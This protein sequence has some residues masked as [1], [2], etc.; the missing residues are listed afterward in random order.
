MTKMAKMIDER[1]QELTHQ[2]HRVM[3]VNSMNTVKELLPILISGNHALLH[4]EPLYCV[5][6]CLCPFL[7]YSIFHT[8]TFWAA[9][10]WCLLWVLFHLSG[11]K[12]FVTTKTSGSHGVEEALKNRNFTFEKMSAEINEII[13]VLQLTS[14]DEDAW[15][16]KVRAINY[17]CRNH[18]HFCMNILEQ[19]ETALLLECLCFLLWITAGSSVCT[20]IDWILSRLTV[21]AHSQNAFGKRP[22]T[23]DFIQR[24]YS[25]L[26]Y[27]FLT[28]HALCLI[29]MTLSQMRSK[30]AFAISP[31]YKQCLKNECFNFLCLHVAG[32]IFRLL[33]RNFSSAL[34]VLLL[35]CP[36][37]ISCATSFSFGDT[38]F[39]D[40]FFPVGMSSST[41]VF[42]SFFLSFCRFFPPSPPVEGKPSPLSPLGCAAACLTD[43]CAVCFVVP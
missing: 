40:T 7:H 29:R 17:K 12:I 8:I 37:T 13:R 28:R 9:I 1:Q 30:N 39:G 42:M 35:S 20:S 43:V 27:F 6:R 3:L 31:P 19:Q 26:V 32:S 38:F 11:I 14:W 22:Q 5:I 41:F 15:A 23:I 2:E 16:N 18:M 34:H 10:S 4:E 36:D 24:C 21:L 25:H 33:L